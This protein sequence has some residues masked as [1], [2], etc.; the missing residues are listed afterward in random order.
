MISFAAS[1]PGV[2]WVRR[3]AESA[4]VSISVDGRHVTDLVVPSSDAIPGA[5]ASDMSGRGATR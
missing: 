4:V 5:S 3:G 2:S 1:A